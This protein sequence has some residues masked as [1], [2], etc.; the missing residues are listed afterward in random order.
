MSLVSIIIPCYRQARYLGQAI[1]S[2]L[3]QTYPHVEVIV[4]DDGSPDEAAEVASRYVGV[5][6][7]RQANRGVAAA[8]NV[9]LLAS[10]GEYVI[11]LDADDR[12]LENAVEIGVETLTAHPNCAF[13]CGHCR[14]ITADGAMVAFPPEKRIEGDHYLALLRHDYIR[15]LATV[16]YRRWVFDEVGLFDESLRGSE[17][18]DLYFRITRRFPAYCH[19]QVMAVYR[20]HEGNATRDFGMMLQCTVSVHRQQWPYVRGRKNYE[21]AYR[22]GLRHLQA[23]Y[24]EPLVAHIRDSLRRGEWQAAAR[25]ASLLARYYPER[26]FRRGYGRRVLKELGRRSLSYLF[27]AHRAKTFPSKGPF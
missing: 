11:F 22:E 5:R 19:G 16:I 13:V 24:G 25:G 7:I 20:W 8:R 18:T 21:Q 15:S 26:L 6:L 23:L 27:G 3:A 2:A 10:G 9:G 17:D 12:L 14:I 1:C 4:V